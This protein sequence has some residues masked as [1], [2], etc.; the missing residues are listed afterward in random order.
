MK[1]VDG[2]GFILDLPMQSSGNFP[3]Q[4]MWGPKDREANFFEYS[5]TI[6]PYSTAK[7]SP[8]DKVQVL[9]AF[10]RQEVLPMEQAGM[11]ARAGVQFDVKEYYR[12]MANLL[13]AQELNTFL[14]INGA[15]MP[16]EPPGIE[17][18]MPASTTRN[19]VRE[20]RSG[21]NGQAGADQ[22]MMAGA[23]G[24]SMP[25]GMNPSMMPQGAA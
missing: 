7:K 9:S 12:T 6:T 20:S 3:Q 13:D 24:A 23:M 25:Q 10:V 14:R 15:A 16:S 21:N 2:A 17:Q 19:Y 5:F 8:R 1:S 4:K 22:S 11:N 18:G